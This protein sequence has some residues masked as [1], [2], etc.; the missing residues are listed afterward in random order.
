MTDLSLFLPGFI[1][2]YTILLV[3]ASSPGPSVAMLIGIA[4]S[5]GRVPALAATLGI[6]VGS[7]TI[8]LLTM[9]GV[10]L[11]LSQ[12]AWAISLLRLIGA[13]YL[14]YLACGAFRKALNPPVLQPVTG[15]RR[16]AGKHFMAGYLLQITNPKAIAFWLAIASV[17]ATDGA[18]TGIVAIF[19]AGAFLISFICHGA[20]AMAL[21]AHP[22]RLAYSAGRRWIELTLGAF[23]TF[24]AYKLATSEN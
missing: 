22:V 8:N 14:L 7:T 6:A 19:I 20:W 2:A 12:A 15:K 3:G 11:L 17:G 1:A 16:A 13:A 24:A 18:G 9:L 10:G 23:F 5:Q 4:T 21:S